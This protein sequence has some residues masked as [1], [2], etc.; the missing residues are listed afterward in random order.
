MTPLNPV[1]TM[2]TMIDNDTTE[3]GPLATPAGD[4]RIGA[5]TLDGRCCDLANRGHRSGCPNKD[6]ATP[7][8]GG[9]VEK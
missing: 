8:Q 6:V 4:V 9:E 1:T 5:A 2:T 3:D 7:A